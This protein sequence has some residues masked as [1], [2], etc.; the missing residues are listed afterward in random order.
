MLINILY[1][2]IINKSILNLIINVLNMHNIKKYREYIIE[3]IVAKII[4]HLNISLIH[5]F[6]SFLVNVIV[7]VSSK[8]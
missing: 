1:I 3:I 6:L 2:I 8:K 5:L 7:A 4:I